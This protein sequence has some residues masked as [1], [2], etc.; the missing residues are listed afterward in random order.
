[1]K[2]KLGKAQSISQKVRRKSA[3]SKKAQEERL[4]QK[5]KIQREYRKVKTLKNND[6]TIRD[7]ALDRAITACLITGVASIF[8]P[9]L[10]YITI[11]FTLLTAVAILNRKSPSK[12]IH[13]V[14]PVKKANFDQ[15][16]ALINTSNSI[17]IREFPFKSKE[18]V[19]ELPALPFLNA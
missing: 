2:A 1:M 8:M 17:P 3:R 13:K 7:R 14:S 6:G 15:G 12:E 16:I 9:Q 10:G 4:H 19:N 18:I 5:K 11:V